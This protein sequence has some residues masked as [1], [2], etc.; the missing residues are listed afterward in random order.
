MALDFLSGHRQNLD[1]HQVFL[2]QRI[3]GYSLR[4]KT[5]VLHMLAAMTSVYS[6]CFRIAVC[7]YRPAYETNDFHH[8]CVSFQHSSVG[9]IRA[10]W[11][12]RL[13]NCDHG[14]SSLLNTERAIKIGQ[15]L[16][17]H[18]SKEFRILSIRPVTRIYHNYDTASFGVIRSRSVWAFDKESTCSCFHCAAVH[19]FAIAESYA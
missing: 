13:V 19:G 15:F 3:S 18:A 10:R 12:S 1:R 9:F 16:K 8:F 6:L 17:G 5:R 4:L 14:Q 2:H 11:R 7:Q